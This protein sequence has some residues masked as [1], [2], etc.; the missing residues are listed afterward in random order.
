MKTDTNS[1]YDEILAKH[2]SGEMREAGSRTFNEGTAVS[3]DAR[4]AWNNLHDRLLKENL[5][6]AQVEAVNSRFVHYFA[7]RSEID[8]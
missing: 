1:R 6:P 2:L 4:K 8:E 7:S 3:P 5:V